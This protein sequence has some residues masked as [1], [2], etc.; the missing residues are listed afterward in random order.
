MGLGVVFCF[1]CRIPAVVYLL[2]RAQETAAVEWFEDVRTAQVKDGWFGE[3]KKIPSAPIYVRSCY[4]KM[5]NLL[6]D[7]ENLGQIDKQTYVIKGT[8]GIGKTTMLYYLLSECLSEAS[9]FTAVLFATDRCMFV[10]RK[11]TTGWRTEA[12]QKG[13]KVDRN[14]EGK[15][16][17]LVDVAPNGTVKHADFLDFN[18]QSPCT[19]YGLHRLVVVASAG[20][21]LGQL[22]GK[23]GDAQVPHVLHLPVWRQFEFSLWLKKNSLEAQENELDCNCGLTVPRLA[24]MYQQ[25][26]F[27]ALLRN[28][29]ESTTGRNFAGSELP[30]KDAHTMVVLRGSR[31]LLG[32]DEETAGGGDDRHAGDPIG[33]VSSCV[34]A[35]MCTKNHEVIQ[36]LIRDVPRTAPYVFEAMV[37]TQA[38]AEGGLK[39]ELSTGSDL[40]LQFGGTRELYGAK[41]IKDGVLY[42][43]RGDNYPSIDACGIPKVAEVKKFY[44]IQIATGRQHT[45]IQ[46]KHLAHIAVPKECVGGVVC[47]YIV[48]TTC[49]SLTLQDGQGALQEGAQKS[50]KSV[51][52]Q[53]ACAKSILEALPSDVKQKFEPGRH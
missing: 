39:L 40:C 42:R 34:E 16:I 31:E 20:S 48:P 52:E 8:S 49:S 28:F 26:K 24:V 36:R 2:F 10:A 35:E 15:A 44:F 22:I 25:G 53:V 50:G 30:H 41:K 46:W 4:E 3:G 18:T 33:W 43:P 7:K 5:R 21:E 19:V 1:G 47:L 37:L 14:G 27:E 45:R 13:S 29:I 6:F 11:G 23:N 32:E 9:P 12:F 38:V 17:G 51:S